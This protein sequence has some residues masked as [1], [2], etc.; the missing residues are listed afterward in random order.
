[1]TTP[2]RTKSQPVLPAPEETLSAGRVFLDCAPRVYRL[3]RLLL[4]NET[5]AEDATEEVF[6]QV[7]RKLPTFRGDSTFSTWLFRVAVNAILAFRRRRGLRRRREMSQ[8][9]EDV[10]E[11]S[12]GGSGPRGNDPLAMIIAR[13][14]RESIEQAIAGLPALYR[15]VLV[16]AD[17]EDRPNQDIAGVLGLSLP[18]VKSRL[19][20]ARGL[21]RQ[22]L[23]PYFE[24]S[25]ERSPVTA[26]NSAQPRHRDEA[27]RP[28]PAA[29]P[30]INTSS[31]SGRPGSSCSVGSSSGTSGSTRS[32]GSSSGTSGSSRS[33]NSSH[34]LDSSHSHSS[35]RSSSS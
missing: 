6:L 23:R 35:V 3:A 25:Q 10:A 13:E 7:V 4:G 21:M 31:R 5:D 34:S 19:H 24:D 11:G 28:S 16:L 20:R 14:T 32:W 30:R 29:G 9:L 2:A 33:W 8:P 18:A 17:V 26:A 12:V 1:M 27:S 22:A 15:D